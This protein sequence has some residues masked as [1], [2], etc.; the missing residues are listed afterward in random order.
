MSRAIASETGFAVA[1]A[2]TGGA[3]AKLDK[4]FLR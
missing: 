2:A 1:N 4:F 3:A